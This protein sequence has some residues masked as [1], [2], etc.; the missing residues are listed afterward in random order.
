MGWSGAHFLK[1]KKVQKK[2]ASLGP[3]LGWFEGR[4]GGGSGVQLGCSDCVN[5][6]PGYPWIPRKGINEYNKVTLT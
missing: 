3:N 1:A 2:C 4:F 5:L 6:G